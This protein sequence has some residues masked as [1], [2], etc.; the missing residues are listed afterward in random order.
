[1]EKVTQNQKRN[2]ILDSDDEN[3]SEISQSNNF[4]NT[5]ERNATSGTRGDSVNSEQSDSDLNTPASKVNDISSNSIEKK[6]KMG[7]L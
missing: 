6:S 7:E 3:E 4:C 5:A 1:M 2:R